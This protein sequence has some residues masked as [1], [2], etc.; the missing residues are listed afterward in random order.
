MWWDE[1]EDEQWKRQ[2]W[3]KL[4]KFGEDGEEEKGS[5]KRDKTNDGKKLQVIRES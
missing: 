3:R 5:H 4:S 1:V 2:Q